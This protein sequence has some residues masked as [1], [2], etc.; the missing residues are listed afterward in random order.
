MLTGKIFMVTGKRPGIFR[1]AF[2][3]IELLVV[4]AIIAILAAMLL[5]TLAKAKAMALQTQCYNNERQI[6]LS[7]FMFVDDYSGYLP[8]GPNDMYTGAAINYGLDEGQFASYDNTSIYQLVY[9]LTPYLHIPAPITGSNFS[10]IF[11]CPAAAAYNISGYDQTTR[12]F[13]GIYIWQHAAMSNNL[14][15]DPFGYYE[16]SGAYVLTNSFKLNQVGNYAPLSKVWALTEV[17]D[18]GS[19]SSGWKNE[20][21]PGP[22][23]NNHRN[24][25]YFDGHVQTEQPTVKG[26]Y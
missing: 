21:P 1:M 18:L 2:T 20:I 15:I 22:I 25:L 7:I 9:Y 3:L 4:I 14:P 10:T 26:V 23:H 24:Y 16:T 11:A 5:P 12:P 19:P 17:D 13:Y 8:P 6:G